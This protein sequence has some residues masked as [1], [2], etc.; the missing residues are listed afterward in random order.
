MEASEVLRDYGLVEHDI[1]FTSSLSVNPD[2][3]TNDMMNS[4]FK[5]LQ[6]SVVLN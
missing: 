2:K 3:A 4:V 6:E 1:K 5:L